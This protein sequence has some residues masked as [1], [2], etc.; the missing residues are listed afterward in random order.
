MRKK[1]NVKQTNEKEIRLTD[2]VNNRKQR[3]GFV[4]E[5]NMHLCHFAHQHQQQ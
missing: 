4:L 3:N 2:E 5:W 1:K